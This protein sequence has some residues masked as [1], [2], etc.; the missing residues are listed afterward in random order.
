MTRIMYGPR[1]SPAGSNKAPIHLFFDN[2]CH[3]DAILHKGLAGRT[4]KRYLSERSQ[5]I[6]WRMPLVKNGSRKN[7]P[8]AALR[9]TIS[10]ADCTRNKSSFV[11][12]L[13]PHGEPPSKAVF[14]IGCGGP[15]ALQVTA[16]SYACVAYRSDHE[17]SRRFNGPFA[18]SFARVEIPAFFD[19]LRCWIFQAE[20]NASAKSAFGQYERGYNGYLVRKRMRWLAVGYYID[21]RMRRVDA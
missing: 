6:R 16:L 2:A 15:T 13:F 17:D 18:D 19:W 11:C 10:P 4:G 21:P 3:A 12:Q 20:T 5:L 7:A 9:M 8:D 14:R 1:S